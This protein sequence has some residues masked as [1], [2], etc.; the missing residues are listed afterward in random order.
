[1]KVQDLDEDTALARM[2]RISDAVKA[3]LTGK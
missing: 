1:M 3:R 2:K